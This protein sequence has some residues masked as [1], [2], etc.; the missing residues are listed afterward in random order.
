[1]GFNPA[2]KRVGSLRGGGRRSVT[3]RRCI[4]DGTRAVNGFD[5]EIEDGEFMVLVGPFG[6]RQDDGAAHGRRARADQRGRRPD[7]RA[8]RQPRAR[9]RPRHRDGLPELRALSA[10]D[11]LRQ[12]R[13]RPAPAQGAEGRDRPAR[14]RRRAH[15]RA[16][17]VPRPQAS[18]PLGR[19]AAARGDGPGDRPPAAGVP[20]GRAA[21]EPRREAARAHARRDR[22]PASTTSA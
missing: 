1:M 3:W 14:A 22:E 11:R 16:R 13:V 7:R 17:G 20:H 18:C 9:A 12:H 10:P 19:P 5:L 4:P 6:L 8:G 21:L 2:Q 15:P